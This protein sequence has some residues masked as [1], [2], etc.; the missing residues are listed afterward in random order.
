MFCDQFYGLLNMYFFPA[1]VLILRAVQIE[2][3]DT[4][5]IRASICIFNFC[6]VL[7]FIDFTVPGIQIL[8]VLNLLKLIRI[9]ILKSI[10]GKGC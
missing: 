3:H 6:Q 1:Q 10:N 2:Q 4:K 5:S 7:N 8:S 9:L